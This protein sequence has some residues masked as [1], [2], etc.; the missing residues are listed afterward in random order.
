MLFA[1]FGLRHLIVDDL[2]DLSEVE[3]GTGRPRRARL[4]TRS[5]PNYR[6]H[7]PRS[8][9]YARLRKQLAVLS[10]AAD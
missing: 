4:R 2:M 6:S 8:R 3:V 10:A 1:K 5:R 7:L 9:H